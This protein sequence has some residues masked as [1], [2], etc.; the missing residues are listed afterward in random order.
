[1]FILVQTGLKSCTVSAI[2]KG[3]VFFAPCKG[4]LPLDLKFGPFFL[5]PWYSP[6]DDGQKLM[7]K[8]E[9][10]GSSSNAMS[11]C[12]KRIEELG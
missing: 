10:F 6:E 2:C 7:R 11:K 3:C 5:K 12:R 8:K 9:L 4:L 1:M